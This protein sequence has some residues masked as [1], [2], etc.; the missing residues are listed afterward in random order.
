M[1]EI[2]QVCLCCNHSVMILI[3]SSSLLQSFSYDFNILDFSES[4]EDHLQIVR[5]AYETLHDGKTDE[6][7]DGKTDEI[8]GML[9]YPSSPEALLLIDL[10]NFVDKK[11]EESI[12]KKDIAMLG[13]KRI[14]CYK[15]YSINPVESIDIATSRNSD[16]LMKT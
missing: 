16:S 15:D 5:F 13:P 6:L 10:E 14:F 11:Y 8:K 1:K 9:Y 3:S 12:T 2:F 4:E 7:C